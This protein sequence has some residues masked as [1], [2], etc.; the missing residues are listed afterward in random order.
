[1]SLRREIWKHKKR[2]EFKKRR[3]CRFIEPG[4]GYDCI[5]CHGLDFVTWWVGKS[6]IKYSEKYLNDLEQGF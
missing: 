3:G 6:K 2:G 5:Y 4:C 1:M